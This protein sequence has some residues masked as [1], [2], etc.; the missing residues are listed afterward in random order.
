MTELV[1]R[2]GRPED[3]E[4]MMALAMSAVADKGL[5]DAQP[6]DL[7]QEL[8]PSLNLDRGIVGVVD[9]SPIRAAALLLIDPI[10][11]N[12][13]KDW[14]VER[15]IFV[16]PECRAAKGGRARLLRSEEHTSELQS[17]LN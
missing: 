16:D 13:H 9:E 2:T 8:W 5:A 7:L 1:V 4:E 17:P 10:W 11:Y 6:V 15:A 14:I 3:V 12:K